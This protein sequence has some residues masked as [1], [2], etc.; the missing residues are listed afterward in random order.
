MNTR[1]RLGWTAIL[2]MSAMVLGGCGFF[3]DDTSVPEPDDVNYPVNTGVRQ[4]M[5]LMRG[6]S[7]V[8]DIYTVNPNQGFLPGGEQIHLSGFFPAVAGAESIYTVYFG[9][10]P[11]A[12]APIAQAYSVYNIYVIA[13]PGDTLGFVNVNLIENA[14]S[15]YTIYE[16]NGYEYID[17]FQ[18]IDVDPGLG[19]VTGG[20]NA[21]VIGFFPV[22]TTISDL[23]A[24]A[25]AYTVYFGSEIA[26]FRQA[27][28]LDPVITSTRMYVTV[29]PKPDGLPGFVD[30]MVV[31]SDIYNTSRTLPNGYQYVGDFQLLD[32]IPDRGPFG[33]GNSVRLNGFFSSIINPINDL[34]T[35]NAL[36]RVY[37]GT[38]QAAFDTSAA[39]LITA[40]DIYT[41]APRAISLGTVD[42]RI[43]S[44]IDGIY[45]TYQNVVDDNYTYARIMQIYSIYPN[46]GPFA[47]GNSVRI[48]GNFPVAATITSMTEAESL[49]NVFF[50]DNLAPFSGVGTSPTLYIERAIGGIYGRYDILHVSAPAG[51]T[52]GFVDVDVVDLTFTDPPVKAIDGYLYNDDGS[53]GNWLDADVFP[54]PVGPL[55][56]GEL[57]VRIEVSGTFSNTFQ[58]FIVPQGG[59]PA[60]PDHRIR[61]ERVTSDPDNQ[62]WIGTNTDAITTVQ[63]GS[64]TEILYADGHA[65]IY[66]FEDGNIVGDDFSSPFTDGGRII[67]DALT[68]RHFIIDTI[69]PIMTVNGGSL[70]ADSF[71]VFNLGDYPSVPVGR[72]LPTG[73]N[74]GTHPYLPGNGVTAFT[75]FLQHAPI[76]EGVITDIPLDNPRGA[77]KFFN[78]ASRSNELD[79]IAGFVAPETNLQFTVFVDFV[80]QDLYTALGVL[81]SEST[82]NGDPFNGGTT[83]RQVAGFG[84]LDI[85][86]SGTD[87]TALQFNAAPLSTTDVRTS[88]V[89][90]ARWILQPGS[91]R[92][93]D[94]NN[95]DVSYITSPSGSAFTNSVFFSEVQD[96]M[97][98]IWDFTGTLPTSGIDPDDVDGNMHLIVKFA[99]SDRATAYFPRGDR[100]GRVQLTVTEDDRRLDPLHL[101]WMQEVN[102]EFVRN[103]VPANGVT[104]NPSFTWRLASA[105]RPVVTENPGGTELVPAYT[106]QIWRT[107]NSQDKDEYR[108]GPY[109][110]VHIPWTSWSSNSSYTENLTSQLT[111]NLDSWYL[112]VVQ[113]TDE[114]G[115]AELFPSEL[116]DVI[117]GIGDGIPGNS[118][119]NWQRFYVPSVAET[120]E[121]EV[122]PLF[123][124]NTDNDTSTPIFDLDFPVITE[125]PGSGE[126]NFGSETVIPL[127]PTN[128]FFPAANIVEQRVEA[129]FN[130]R[131]LSNNTNTSPSIFW[132]LF[133]EGELIAFGFIPETT[134]GIVI[135]SS[136]LVPPFFLGDPNRVR[137]I[138]YLFSARSVILEDPL[139][140][141]SPILAEDSTPASIRFVVVPDVAEYVRNRQTEDEQPIKEFDRP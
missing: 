69:P 85:S 107:F 46:V 75:Q 65:A 95:I 141:N 28:A 92:L 49:Y 1:H 73:A 19:P 60:D 61:L 131:V 109:D 140:P 84:D 3:G 77:Q 99:A 54:N 67:G 111:D 68:G 123:W 117:S 4:T 27:A 26:S 66:L 23:A 137:E 126:R 139:N 6:M 9:F 132:N 47:G 122:T 106:Y 58:A 97:R 22:G 121:T 127:P 53:F 40:T 10:N 15:V 24:A 70:N 43:F 114:A 102:T 138:N 104:Q 125:S 8:Y 18:V 71:V 12:Y 25:S 72:F 44:I 31:A 108:D 129:R 120:L 79:E 91:T 96:E 88:P 133:Q 113:G 136:T 82:L 13:P 94:V 7:S 11:A 90:L 115:N 33:G 87:S 36:Y 63:F 100:T 59:N 37:F 74:F 29:P 39:S 30:V 81:P 5:E 83:E 86:F 101:W 55:R 78:V 20:N 93:P 21:D 57:Y 98:A 51:N 34:V 112:L 64:G 124:H 76:D 62:I 89:F 135:A 16:T 17:T 14:A 52:L 35:A 56:A 38:E 118:G 48:E 105:P 41:I 130:I 116:N 110:E 128:V 103:N 45:N 2:L 119:P 134:F 42:V 50:E 32:V 80:D